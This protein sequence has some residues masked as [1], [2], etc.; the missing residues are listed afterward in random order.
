MEIGLFFLF[1]TSC[2]YCCDLPVWTGFEIFAKDS[3]SLLYAICEGTVIAYIFYIFQVM[4]PR[5]T[6]YRRMRRF[7]V[8]KLGKLEC[9]MRSLLCCLQ[10]D[11]NNPFGIFDADKIKGHLD[12]INIFSTNSEMLIIDGREHSVCEALIY[13]R[14][15]IGN[16]I[17]QITT[18]Q[19]ISERH[20]EELLRVEAAKMHSTIEW[21]ICNQTGHFTRRNQ[22][23][24]GY[25]WVNPN[26]IR[27]DL[28]SA[29]K[30]YID[31]YEDVKKLWTKQY[32]KS[33]T[34]TE[35]FQ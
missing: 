22:E 24:P 1:M 8:N 12:S 28:S 35:H 26:V 3:G 21:L 10:G 33:L 5:V 19:Y 30:E 16:V 20:E 6:R 7:V 4:I 23:M 27:D 34:I 17:D 9:A 11:R 13:Y 18:G 31:F 32:H 14:K 25:K 15:E 2:I 29:A